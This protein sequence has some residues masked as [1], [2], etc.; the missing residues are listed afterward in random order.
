MTNN[1]KWFLKTKV[2]KLFVPW[3]QARERLIGN[4]TFWTKL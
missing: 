2:G 1:R 4:V 3:L